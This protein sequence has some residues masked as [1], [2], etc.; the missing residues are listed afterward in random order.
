MSIS[1]SQFLSLSQVTARYSC[2]RATV[3]RL[4]QKNR[5]PAPCK[6][7]GMSRWRMSELEAWECGLSRGTLGEHT[8]V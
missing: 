3:Y 5:M 8:K 4:I 6:I 1:E 2:S 7:G